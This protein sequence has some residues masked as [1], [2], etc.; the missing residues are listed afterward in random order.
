MLKEKEHTQKAELLAA[1]KDLAEKNA[2]IVR[3]SEFCKK[4]RVEQK[5]LMEK[6]GQIIH[7][8]RKEL[9]EAK[10]KLERTEP[11]KLNQGD[12]CKIDTFKDTE[13]EA[14]NYQVKRN[15]DKP[16]PDARRFQEA[17]EPGGIEIEDNESLSSLELQHIKSDREF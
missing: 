9:A 14:T 4:R 3:H 12:L 15:L 6:K 11:G 2:D 17:G 1:Q 7:S 5:K 8:L 13:Y 16:I 10:K